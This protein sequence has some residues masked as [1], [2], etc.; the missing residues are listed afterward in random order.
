MATVVVVTIVSMHGENG[1]IIGSSS[2][3]SGC[4]YGITSSTFNSYCR[5]QFS[6][7]IPR[8]PRFQADG[9][10]NRQLTFNCH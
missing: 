4:S 5:P 2:S 10:I 8:D 6:G 7:L 9:C 1:S 3:I